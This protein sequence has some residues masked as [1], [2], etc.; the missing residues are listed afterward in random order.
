MPALRSTSDTSGLP[1]ALPE[2]VIGLWGT[3]Q[4]QETP[5]AHAPACLKKIIKTPRAAFSSWH[6]QRST[7]RLELTTSGPTVH[8]T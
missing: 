2:P 7:P 5:V 4:S 6:T 8:H 3:P 1:P